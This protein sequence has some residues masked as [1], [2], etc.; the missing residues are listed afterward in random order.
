M[1]NKQLNSKFVDNLMDAILRLRTRDEARRFLR[2]L[3]T[4]Q[5]ILEFANRWQVAQMLYQGISYSTIEKET[6]MSSTTIAR[7]S[8]WLNRGRGG[9]RFMLK[10]LQAH[11]TLSVH[12]KRSD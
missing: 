5:E 11:H 4:K 6:G 12:K 10:R 1:I 7:I 9:Y 3:L 2:D 8:R